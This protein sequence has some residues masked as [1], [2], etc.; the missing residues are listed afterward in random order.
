[1]ASGGWKDPKRAGNGS[2]TEKVQIPSEFLVQQFSGV[3]FFDGLILVERVFFLDLFEVICLIFPLDKPIFRDDFSFPGIKQIH[4]KQVYRPI[5]E[6]Y[7]PRLLK[8]IPKYVVFE[9]FAW[10]NCF[11]RT[12]TKKIREDN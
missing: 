3:H 6:N 9:S 10:S 4:Q 1:M 8:R 2:F 11:F 5:Y 7:D 12:D